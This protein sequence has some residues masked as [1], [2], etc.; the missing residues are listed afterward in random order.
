M[1]GVSFVGI[2]PPASHVQGQVHQRIFTALSWWSL[3]FVG[4]WVPLGVILS[5]G[6][7]GVSLDNSSP[8]WVTMLLFQGLALLAAASFAAD[9]LVRLK[10]RDVSILYLRKFHSEE[11]EA[12]PINPFDRDSGLASNSARRARRFRLASMLEGIGLLGVRVI[13]L[14]DARTPGSGHVIFYLLPLY[15]LL[16]LFAPAML[17]LFCCWGL[18]ILA[19]WSIGIDANH[20]GALLATVLL[21]LV[22][23]IAL[24]PK[25][26]IWLRNSM[27]A[28]AERVRGLLIP[29][30][31]PRSLDELDRLFARA[32][33]VGPI[34]VRSSDL[35]WE[36]FVE[37]LLCCSD[38]TLFDIRASS[39][40]CEKE[41]R[42]IR[43]LQLQDRVIWLVHDLADVIQERDGYR[44]GAIGF[45]GQPILI[46]TSQE[47]PRAAFWHPID[48][49]KI[50][51]V[52]TLIAT[53]ERIVRTARS[54]N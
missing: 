31:R 8:L 5:Y 18:S 22:G 27:E 23:L 20:W 19:A 6:L 48:P 30:H 10:R 34:A 43:Q 12:F 38:V 1:R 44:V 17:I 53:A 33:S 41:L 45:P 25:A 24:L 16:M 4:V 46:T 29:G 35:N 49:S 54:A 3:I 39:A 15:L 2:W 36:K 21:A 13:A 40:N 7:R 26:R 42:L 28:H 47:P 50:Q 51:F 52:T 32:Q 11:R 9:M 37:R 14:R